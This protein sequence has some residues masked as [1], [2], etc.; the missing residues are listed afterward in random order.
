MTETTTI[1]VLVADDHAVVRRGLQSLIDSEPG[2]EVVGEATDGI[3]ALFKVRA[4][5]PDVVLMD[6]VMPSKDGLEAIVEIKAEFPDVRILVLTS[7]PDDDKVF[8]AIKAGA[9]GYLLKDSSPTDLLQA[10]RYV[11]QGESS[12]AP[13]VALKVIQEMHQAPPTH[14]TPDALTQREIEVLEQVAQGLTNLE[15][16]ADLGI[17]ERTVRNHVGHILDKLHLANRTQAALYALR[18]GFA[19][20]DGKSR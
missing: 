19:S 15:I 9:L 6:L 17:S 2:M 7:F 16:A 1:R 20:L 5:E 10:I 13:S 4:L 11:N 3:D 14:S 18:E 12:L 8:P